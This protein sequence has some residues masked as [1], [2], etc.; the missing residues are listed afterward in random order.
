MFWE[1]L[2]DRLDKA[3]C[4]KR[5]KDQKKKNKNKT[6]DLRPTSSYVNKFIFRTCC[7]RHFLQL[8][9]FLKKK[10]FVERDF[11]FYLKKFQ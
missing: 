9:N 4:H 2:I 5:E 1:I 8:Q 10:K 7:E 11:S 6:T 3:D